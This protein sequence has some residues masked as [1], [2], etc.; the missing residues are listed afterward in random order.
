MPAFMLTPFLHAHSQLLCSSYQRLTGRTLIDQASAPLPTG[1]L[2]AEALYN[3]DVAVVSH[4]T[5]ADPIFNYANRQA[6]ALFAYDWAQF[7]SLPSRLSA[8]PMLREA[9]DAL[10]QRVARDGYVD[11][12]A[13]VRVAGDGRRFMI[14]RATVWNLLD[15]DG[16]Y[17]GQAAC[18]HD[19]HAI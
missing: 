9:R 15:A 16:T 13:G 14:T 12:Y 4:D 2:L 3:A 5:A 7:V 11:D 19:W 6:Q 18:I 10:L 17:R 8:E 1:M